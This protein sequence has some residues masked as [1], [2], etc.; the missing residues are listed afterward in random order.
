MRVILKRNFFSSVGRFRANGKTPIEMPDSLIDKLPKD[1]V[2]VEK[3]KTSRRGG[4]PKRQ[5][6]LEEQVENT[7][8]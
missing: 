5:D 1:A 2:V 6:K 4:R 3:P 8:E 7:E